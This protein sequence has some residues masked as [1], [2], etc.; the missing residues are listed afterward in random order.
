M[1]NFLNMTTETPDRINAGDI[2]CWSG[3][4]LVLFYET[5]SNSYGGYIRLGYVNDPSGFAAALGNNNV[6]VS[7]TRVE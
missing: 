5:F 7:F 6:Q 2:M 3:N 1:K 4:C